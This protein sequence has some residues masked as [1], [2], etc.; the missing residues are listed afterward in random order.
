ISNSSPIPTL[1]SISPSNGTQGQSNIT[2]VLN[3]N[4]FITGSVVS[5]SNSGIIIN[6]TT[7]NNSTTIT[8]DI[9]IS[10]NAQIGLS[11]VSVSNTNGISN[12]VSFRVI[13]YNTCLVPT[14]SSISPAWAYVG[15]SSATVTIYGSNFSNGT[16]GQYNG[17]I[18]TTNFVNSG[19][20]D[21]ILTSSDLSSLGTGNITV[22]NGSNYCTSGI[23]T[24]SV[25]SNN[26]GGG[27]GLVPS[28]SSISP[29][30]VVVGSGAITIN[31]Y[32]SNFTNNSSA[33]I[34][35]GARQTNYVNSGQ[36]V[37]N[38]YYSDTSVV[39]TW[40]IYVNSGSG[41]NSNSTIFNVYSN[42]FGGGGGGGNGGGNGG[43]GHPI[44]Y[45]NVITQNATNISKYSAVLNGSINPN[46]NMTTAWFEYGTSYNLGTYSDTNHDY[47]GSGGS[48]SILSQSALNLSPNTTY[49]F[50][51][52]ANNY[53]GT[54]RGSIFSFTTGI[55][56]INNIVNGN[57]TVTR[58][59]YQD[60]NTDNIY[61]DTT[62]NN[63]PNEANTGNQTSINNDYF[64]G[65]DLGASALFGSTNI[66]PKTFIGWLIFLILI[67]IIIIIGRKLYDDYSYQK[68]RRKVDAN[69]IENLP[70]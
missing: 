52:V 69:N 29:S 21:M 28:I 50:R 46:N 17:T 68:K 70:T 63:S 59:I 56:V 44:Y 32:G 13:A 7:I 64:N 31:I 5:F 33:Y 37:M 54:I 4:G 20:V 35:G 39:G 25:N 55:N 66:L 34:N 42:N 27:G 10:S 15:T 12:T 22:T 51:A 23:A 38:L 8:L 3:G 18:R 41:N 48:Y 26:S 40:N 6:S 45:V 30:S 16:N 43:G 11:N 14:I 65:K 36:L 53:A 60:T 61:T 1:I 9:S 67:F 49:Y 19:Q 62:N 58:I 47:F 24:F 2:A 57:K